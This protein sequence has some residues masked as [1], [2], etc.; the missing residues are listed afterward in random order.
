MSSAAGEIKA[1]TAWSAWV[2]PDRI[3]DSGCDYQHSRRGGDSAYQDYIARAQMTEAMNLLRDAKTPV[4]EYFDNAGAWPT[5]A[6]FT[7]IVS[8]QNEKY[9]L[10]MTALRL[11]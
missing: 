5:G 6:T 2:Y 9:V 10:S 8:S 7:N 1:V 4:A 11:R 3:D